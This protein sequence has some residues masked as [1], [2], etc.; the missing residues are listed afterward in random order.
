MLLDELGLLTGIGIFI[1]WGGAPTR[2]AIISNWPVI[3][4]ALVSMGLYAVVLVR[5]SY[6]SASMALLFVAMLAGIRLPRN[7][8]TSPLTKYVAVAV[9]GST[10][11]SVAAYL[12]ETAYVTN[13]VYS[14]PMQ[15]DHIK[16]AEGLRA[17]GLRAGDWVA[18]IGEGRDDYWARLG[19]FK[20]VAEVLSPDVA[21]MQFWTEPSERR[22]LA[23]ECLRN[24]GAKVVVVWAPPSTMD[25][26]WTRVANTNYYAYFLAK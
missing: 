10:L 24:S 1:L 14:S 22:K 15:K 18:V 17:M 4:V 21:R 7:V 19:R 11:F 3:A 25:S 26:G 6:V 12:A 13:T 5:T 2:R 20:I 9:M 23:Y 16:A 8:Q